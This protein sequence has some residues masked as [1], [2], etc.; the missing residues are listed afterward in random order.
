MGKEFKTYKNSWLFSPMIWDILLEKYIPQ[1]IMTPFGYKKSLICDFDRTLWVKLNDALNESD[2]L[3]D[4]VCWEISNQQIF[5]VRDG[6][7]IAR[8]IRQFVE[9]NKSYDKSK[10][11]NLSPLER[12][13]IVKRFNEIAD[14]IE[15]LDWHKH[16]YFVFKNSSCD[17]SVEYWFRKYD[18]KTDSYNPKRLDEWDRYLAEFV[19]IEDGERISRFISNLDYEYQTGKNRRKSVRSNL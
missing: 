11:D 12:E 2:N 14:D 1:D 10:Q 16:E 6:A 17:N 18:E 9:Q 4:R 13:H 15:N 3:A 7:I 8:C 19:E 5:Y